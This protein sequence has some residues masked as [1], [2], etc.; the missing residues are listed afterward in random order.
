VEGS[1]LGKEMFTENA[2]RPGKSSR[3]PKYICGDCDAN[4]AR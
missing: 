1:T 4:C 2:Q 3:R